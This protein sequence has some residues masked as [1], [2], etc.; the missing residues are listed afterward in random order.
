MSLSYVLKI[1]TDES[2]F[3]LISEILGISATTQTLAW[4]LELIEGNVYCNFA[5]YFMNLI[6]PNKERLML[7]GIKDD[8]ITIWCYYEYVEQCNLEFSPG[9]LQKLGENNI[10]LC[11]S[12]WKENS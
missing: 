10:R 5:D 1:E 12:C 9:D 3:D 7:Q 8:D 6:V 2:K 4:E 11:I